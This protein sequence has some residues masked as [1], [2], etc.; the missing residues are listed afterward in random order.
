MVGAKNLQVPQLIPHAQLVVCLKLVAVAGAADTLK[1]FAAV[2]I[3]CPQSPDKSCRNDVI[4]MPL[5]SCPLEIHAAQLH[6]AVST[7]G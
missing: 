3:P 4:N 5:Y 2:W 7:Q 6:F 1:V